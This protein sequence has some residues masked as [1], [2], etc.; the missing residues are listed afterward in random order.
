MKKYITCD[1]Q[2]FQVY[3]YSKPGHLSSIAIFSYFHH[4]VLLLF[5]INSRESQLTC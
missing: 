1:Y 4:P 3:R 5:V 2:V